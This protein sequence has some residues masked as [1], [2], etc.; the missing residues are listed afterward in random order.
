MQISGIQKFTLLDYPNKTAC[1]IFTPGC[2]FRCGFCHNPEFVLPEKIQKIKD[3]FIPEEIFFNFL[4]RR[5]KLLDAVVIS[6]GEPSLM[7][8][9]IEFVTKIKGM[10]FLV[11]LDSNGSRPGVIRDMIQ[12][13]LVDYI[14]MD[15]KTSLEKYTSLVGTS[16]NPEKIEESIKIIM[17]SG[18]PYEFRSTIVKEDHPREVLEQ[19]ARL[20]SGAEK[21]YLQRFRP[22][23]VLNPKYNDFS[24]YSS[25]EM[26]DIAKNIFSPVIKEV[27]VRE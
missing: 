15:I 3:S 14:A 26:E 13:K 25:E 24:S 4:E 18:L 6:G 10:G 2:N 27:S 5:G 16:G 11:K 9:I 8:D 12:A 23:T 22:G 1:V 17:D 21:Y 7:P 20:I 19:M